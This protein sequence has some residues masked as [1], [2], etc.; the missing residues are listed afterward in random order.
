[1]D[2]FSLLPYITKR[3]DNVDDYLLKVRGKR[4]KQQFKRIVHAMELG[5]QLW[6]Y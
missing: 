2:D 6:E 4:L 5:D 3:I 1:M